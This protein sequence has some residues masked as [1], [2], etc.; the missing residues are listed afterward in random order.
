MRQ[1]KKSPPLILGACY[2]KAKFGCSKNANFA[3]FRMTVHCDLQ[4]I[5]DSDVS[6]G[7]VVGLCMSGCLMSAWGLAIHPLACLRQYFCLCLPDYALTS[8]NIIGVGTG[9]RP[10]SGEYMSLCKYLHSLIRAQNTKE[11]LYKVQIN[12]KIVTG[13]ACFV[14]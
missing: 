11:R 7:I 13:L 9:R 2:K 14:Q 10:S 8:F 5:D 4:F 3:I 12:P 6:R 1:R